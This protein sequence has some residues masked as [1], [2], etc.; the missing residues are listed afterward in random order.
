MSISI[1]DIDPAPWNR[2][3]WSGSF[4]CIGCPAIT[5]LK[6]EEVEEVLAWWESGDE[7]DGRTAGLVRLVNGSFVAWE[8]DYGPT[9]NGFSEDAYGGDADIVVA[10][11]MEGALGGI[12]EDARATLVAEMAG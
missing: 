7:W 4:I 9:G 5:D 6:R 11:T 12:G 10:S 3:T 8:C 1:D 2:Y